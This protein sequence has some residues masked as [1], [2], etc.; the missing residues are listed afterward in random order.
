[1]AWATP[2]SSLTYENR[3]Y[4]WHEAMP[5][6][7]IA[8]LA[9]ADPFISLPPEL[10]GLL[11][12][13]IYHN[14]T[15][16]V[17]GQPEFPCEMRLDMADVTLELGEGDMAHNLTLSPYDYTF[18][19]Y[20]SSEDIEVCVFGVLR[21]HASQVALGWPFLR[22]FYTILDWDERRIRFVPKS[23]PE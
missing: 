14:I 22:R 15:G 1:M 21:S 17:G 8:V 9:S 12:A 10:R 23:D 2:L 4:E 6:S 20:R 5:S 19:V 16:M 3:T 13:Q 18:K 7:S 11:F